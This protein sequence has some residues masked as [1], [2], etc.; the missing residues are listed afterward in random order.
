[1]NNDLKV[2]FDEFNE[3]PIVYHRIYAKIGGGVTAGLL[4][5]QLVYWAKAMK[6]KEFYKT[7]KD[8]REELCM[9][10]YELS[11]AKKKL[12]DLGIITMKRK[13][14]PAKTY[15]TVDISK[16]IK[17]ISQ[18]TSCMETRQLVVGK[19]DNYSAGNQTTITESTTENKTENT[20]L[21][22]DLQSAGIQSNSLVPKTADQKKKKSV[23]V[24]SQPLEKVALVKK[25]K[26]YKYNNKDRIEVID[27]FHKAGNI[28]VKF[29]N[30]TFHKNIEEMFDAYGIEEIKKFSRWAIEANTMQYAPT[31]TTPS[32]LYRKLPQ[33]LSFVKK[34]VDNKNDNKRMSDSALQKAIKTMQQN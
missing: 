6:Y 12:K 2:L 3:K 15:Y 33:L 16:I 14:I 27:I 31:I 10:K 25:V 28:S 4:L 8:F 34:T 7:D 18:T 23:T 32:Q 1:M 17:L 24:V 29:G 9:G 26:K 21:F 11:G 13:G 22:A 5:S 19:P 20:T 30:K